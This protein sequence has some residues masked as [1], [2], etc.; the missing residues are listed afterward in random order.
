MKSTSQLHFEEVTPSNRTEIE[1]LEIFSEQSG[2]IESVSA[3]LQEADAL[4]LWRPVGIYDGSTL[5]GFA[6]YGFFPEL[7]E[8]WL[9]R[10]LIDKRYQHKGYGGQAVL[11]LLDRLS[12]E[13]GKDTIYLSVYGDNTGAIQLYQRIGFVLTEGTTP[14]GS[15]SWSIMSKKKQP[16]RPAGPICSLDAVHSRLLRW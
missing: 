9:D 11:A 13:Y 5:I 14:R 16:P 3:C 15:A 12:T 6:M 7:G 4:D 2:F 8:L 10:L 1:K